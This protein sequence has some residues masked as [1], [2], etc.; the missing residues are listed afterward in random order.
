MAFSLT[1]KRKI[2]TKTLG[3]NSLM[4][5][6]NYFPRR[7]N[8]YT[9]QVLDESSDGE[10]TVIKAKVIDVS[11]MARFQRTRVRYTVYLDYNDIE[12]KG[13]V[14]NREYMYSK[15]KTGTEV[16]ISGKYNHLKKEIVVNDLIFSEKIKTDEY[17]KPI[18][19][20]ASGIANREIVSLVR[21]AYNYASKANLLDDIIP[22]YLREKYRLISRKDAYNY[23]HN[24][25]NKE[26][27]KQAYRYLKFEELL[28]FALAIIKTKY[29]RESIAFDKRYVDKELIKNFISSLPYSLTKDQ[30]E[31]VNDIINDLTSSKTMHRL[32]QGDVGTGKTLVAIITLIGACTNNK[33]AALMAPTDILARQHFYNISSLTKNLPFKV[34]LLVSNMPTS[35]KREVLEGI[36]NSE[37]DIV[38]GTHSLIQNQVNFANLG[39]VIIDEQQRFGVNQRLLLKTKGKNTDLLLLSATPIPRTLALALYGDMDISTLYEFPLGKRKIKTKLIMG[40]SIY[41]FIDEVES[42]IRNKRKIYIICPQIDNE[43][44]N[45]HS[46]IKVHQGLVDFFKGKYKIGLLHGKMSDEEK[47]QIVTSFKDEDVHVLVSTTV[48]EVGVDVREADMMIIY[49]AERFG[50]SQLHQLRGR[51]GRGG[52]EGICY[53]LTSSKDENVIRRL[54]LLENCDD[55]FEISHFDLK[56]RGP[57]ELTGVKQSGIANFKIADIVDDM[58]IFEVA[59]VEAER[60][61]PSLEKWEYSKLND[62]VNKYL[63]KNVEVIG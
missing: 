36:S 61:Y 48:V 35:E 18:Y 45:L 26:M 57:G 1:P 34:A 54:T 58:K 47:E 5:I 13:V 50:L 59:K 31:T 30:V 29:E 43:E 2:I 62:K 46:V 60:I 23:V 25:P 17:L 14:F 42:F 8:D 16:I 22:I 44:N 10:I 15:L 9:T 28:I 53:L 63:A 56:N 37:I 51:I 40:K 32:I 21:S 33:Q 52:R 7:Y 20:L 12:L 6:L 4:D 24:P 27:L 38:V 11:P 19:G 49:D 39:L 3:L 55:G 41:P